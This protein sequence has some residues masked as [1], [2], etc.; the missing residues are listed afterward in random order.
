M[1][2]IEKKKEKNEAKFPQD[3]TYPP[4]YTC[5][6]NPRHSYPLHTTQIRHEL[7]LNINNVAFPY[8]ASGGMVM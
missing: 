5:A 1:K 3:M 6:S 8:N 2:E 4:I 7:D